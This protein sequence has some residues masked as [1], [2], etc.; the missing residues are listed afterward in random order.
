MT[1]KR[2]ASNG[3]QHG[4]QKQTGVSKNHHQSQIAATNQELQQQTKQNRN[5]HRE[6]N[7]DQEQDVILRRALRMKTLHL[8]SSTQQNMQETH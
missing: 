6:F 4:Q 1:E 3:R 8:Q 7:N 5:N 2:K